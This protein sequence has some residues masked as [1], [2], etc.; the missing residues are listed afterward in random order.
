MPDLRADSDFGGR[1]TEGLF[2]FGE[3]GGF[4]GYF[5]RDFA[6]DRAIWPP[7]YIVASSAS[8]YDAALI[9]PV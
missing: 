8:E 2:C 5:R 9:D 6:G 4:S 7:G 3:S 1:E